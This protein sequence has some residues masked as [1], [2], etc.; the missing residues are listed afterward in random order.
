MV[1][2]RTEQMKIKPVK[3]NGDWRIPYK[4]KF[5]LL[6]FANPI[7]QKEPTNTK[8]ILGMYTFPILSI[9]S[10]LNFFRTA[11]LE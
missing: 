2:K 8:A 7:V 5:G 10:N 6:Y 1:N 9:K 3:P 11:T 4:L